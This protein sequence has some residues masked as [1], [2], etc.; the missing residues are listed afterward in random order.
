MQTHELSRYD[1]EV[2]EKALSTVLNR[3]CETAIERSRAEQLRDQFRA[4]HTVKIELEE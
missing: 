1:F 3:G 4:A 2:L